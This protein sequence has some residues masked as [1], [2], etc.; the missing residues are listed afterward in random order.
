M[1]RDLQLLREKQ[2][3]V[4]VIGGGITGACVAHD[5][6]LRGLRV[7]LLEKDDFISTAC[8]RC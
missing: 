1:N 5:A 6:S 8:C 4:I 7:A 3:D 2:Y